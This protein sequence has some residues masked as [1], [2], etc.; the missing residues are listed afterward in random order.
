[1]LASRSVPFLAAMAAC[2]L[3]GAVMFAI[4]GYTEEPTELVSKQVTQVASKAKKSA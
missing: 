4:S 3:V 1:M 2:A